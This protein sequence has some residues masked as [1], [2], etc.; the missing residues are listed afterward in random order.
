LADRLT[1][2]GRTLV[3]D[4]VRIEDQGQYTCVSE[5]SAG[6]D[7][8]TYAVLIQPL[9]IHVHLTDVQL[10]E[11]IVTA[12]GADRPVHNLHVIYR[13]LSS[14]APFTFA[15]VFTPAMNVFHLNNLVAATTYEVCV[16]LQ[17][18]PQPISCAR[19]LTPPATP[20]TVSDWGQRATNATIGVCLGVL[21]MLLVALCLALI[22][23]QLKGEH[24]NQPINA[25]LHYD[26]LDNDDFKTASP[27]TEM[28][29]A[30][31]VPLS[32]TSHTI[33]NTV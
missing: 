8:A 27:Y 16:T 22:V 4:S 6:T 13:P 32:R 29:V 17:T 12:T 24:S 15:G 11:M 9:T 21:I 1:D 26:R 3:I 20:T 5:S 33:P 31:Y 2:N 10:H 25:L 30:V 23:A 28:P 7:T 19:E 18:S 14:S